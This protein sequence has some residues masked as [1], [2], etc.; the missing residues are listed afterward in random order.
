VKPNIGPNDYVYGLGLD[1]RKNVGPGMNQ[2]CLEVGLNVSQEVARS[3]T[4]DD[5]ILVR[6]TLA[7]CRMDVDGTVQ[8]NLNKAQMNAPMMVRGVEIVI[9]SRSAVVVGKVN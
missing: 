6:G 5:V 9:D 3:L 7:I 4:V 1:L 8:M 2:E